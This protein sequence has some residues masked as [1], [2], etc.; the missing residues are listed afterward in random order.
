MKLQKKTEEAEKKRLA[1]EFEERKHER[2]RKEIEER[3]R[4]EAQ[5]IINEVGKR[6]KKKG[7][8]PIIEG[9]SDSFSRIFMFLYPRGFKSILEVD[10]CFLFTGERD[11]AGFDGVSNARTS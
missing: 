3:E 11:K 9:V 4:E 8:K 6:I 10:R 2:I 5:A 7:K 1:T